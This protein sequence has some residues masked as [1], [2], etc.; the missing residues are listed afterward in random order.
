MQFRI[1]DFIEE[2]DSYANR[3]F[4]E[5]GPRLQAQ[6]LKRLSVFEEKTISQL[7]KTNELEKVADKSAKLY[8]L[9]IRTSPPVR[10]LGI[11]EENHYKPLC[12]I[13]KKTEKLSQRDIKRAINR[14]Q[15]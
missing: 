15:K 3:E 6:I 13:K 4:R 11:F 14:I 5:L 9:K 12:I 7:F 2:D 1:T 10:M 8:E